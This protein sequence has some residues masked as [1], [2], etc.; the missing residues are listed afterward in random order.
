MISAARKARKTEGK[1]PNTFLSEITTLQKVFEEIEDPQKAVIDAGQI[2]W[3]GEYDSLPLLYATV[4]KTY[5]IAAP[6][7]NMKP[8]RA[9]EMI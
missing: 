7:A 1:L 3:N 9:Q 2:T 6:G 5:A 8:F 4:F